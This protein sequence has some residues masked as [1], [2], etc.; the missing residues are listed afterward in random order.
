MKHF[1]LYLSR[2]NRGSE[3]PRRG[4]R[5]EGLD[6]RRIEIQASEQQTALEDSGRRPSKRPAWG[7]PHGTEIDQD[8]PNTSYPKDHRIRGPPADR[9]SFDPFN[10]FEEI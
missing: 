1:D 3:G 10:S 5:R 7:I 2:E 9:K 8:N 4:L 6:D